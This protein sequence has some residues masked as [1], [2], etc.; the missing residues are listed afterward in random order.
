MLRSKSLQKHLLDVYRA[1]VPPSE[2]ELERRRWGAQ[3]GRGGGRGR[4]RGR[5]RGGAQT[6]VRW[7]QEKGD[8]AALWRLKKVRAG[9]V[10]ENVEV[11]A[12]VRAAVEALEGEGRVRGSA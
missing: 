4:G 5:G 9:G 10:E 8:K 7:T 6:E 3:R 11:E 2:E 12:F 1:G